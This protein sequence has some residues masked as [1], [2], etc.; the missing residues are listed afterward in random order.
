VVFQK[1]RALTPTGEKHSLA[2]VNC[3]PNGLEVEKG[4][5]VRGF[6]ALAALVFSQVAGAQV[7][8]ETDEESPEEDTPSSEEAPYVPR[9]LGGTYG[10][11]ATFAPLTRVTGFGR[12]A[13]VMVGARAGWLFHH[14]LLIG[15]EGHVLASPTVWHKDN[16]QV[17]SM[18]YGGFFAE[19]IVG[20]SRKVQGLF[21]AFWGFGEAHYRSSS[22]LS[23][24]SEVTALMVTELQASLVYA[25]LSWMQ[26]QIGPGFRFATGGELTGLEGQ[27]FWAPYGELSLALGRF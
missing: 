10:K 27:D 25:P 4:G 8:V 23:G 19:R 24:I 15:A 9:L 11:G 16:Q 26:L 1:T 20:H 17:L 7:P 5:C 3:S 12:Q 14:T 21:H 18:T 6:L 13:G 2:G 22:D